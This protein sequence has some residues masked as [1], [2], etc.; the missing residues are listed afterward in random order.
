M[1]LECSQRHAMSPSGKGL[2]QNWHDTANTLR[3]WYRSGLEELAMACQQGTGVIRLFGIAR[4][5]RAAACHRRVFEILLEDY[6]DRLDVEGKRLLQ[7]VRD[8]ATRMGLLIDHILAFSRIGRQ[9]L[10]VSDTDMG[11]LVQDTLRELAPAMADRAI[12]MKVGPLPHVH[13]DPQMLQRVWMNLLT[14]P[15]NT[16]VGNLTR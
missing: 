15:S 11:A 7:V 2:R 1:L 5:A 3:N 13:G 14:T 8:G 4:S 12:E 16:P 9:E 10:A 6:R